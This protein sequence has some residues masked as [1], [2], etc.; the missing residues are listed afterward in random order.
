MSLKF[1]MQ[2]ETEESASIIKNQQID[3]VEILNEVTNRLQ[4]IPPN[5]VATLARGSSDHAASFSKY[6]IETHLGI[7]T[8]SIAPSVHTIYKSNII[9]K[10]SFVIGISQS[11]KSSDLVESM[12][13]ARKSGAITLAFVNDKNSP[14]EQASEYCIPLLANKEQSVAATKSFIASLSRIIQLI[15]Y[16]KKD[17]NLN[18]QLLNTS[19]QLLNFNENEMNLFVENLLNEKS[20]LVIGRGHSFPIALESALKLKETCGLH[21]EAFSGAE[22]LHGPFELIQKNYP[23]LLY[24]SND[25]TLDSM[26]KLIETLQNKNAKIF[27]I[28]TNEIA[29]KYEKNLSNTYI[30]KTANSINSLCDNILSIYHFYKLAAF[31]SQKLGRN[32]DLP[33][34]LNKVTDTI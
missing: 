4:K 24:L 22:I 20:I 17:S 21:A 29:L 7:M 31:L 1:W 13:F 2:K 34:N 8:A 16:W 28:T 10:N 23:I 19:D 6:A 5:F 14:L 11:G 27:I 30:F 26:L 32:P 33:K 18:K 15:S 25:E 3:S 9:Y 12:A